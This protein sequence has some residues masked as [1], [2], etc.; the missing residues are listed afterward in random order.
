MKMPFLLVSNGQTSALSYSATQHTTRKPLWFGSLV[1]CL[2]GFDSVGWKQAPAFLTLSCVYN[3]LSLQAVTTLDSFSHDVSKGFPVQFC[4][5][6]TGLLLP[7]SRGEP[8]TAMGQISCHL[9]LSI[10]FFRNAAM[11]TCSYV[12]CLWLFHTVTA[13]LG[14]CNGHCRSSRQKNIY[15]LPLYKVGWPVVW[16][17]DLQN[18]VCASQGRTRSSV[19]V[20]WTENSY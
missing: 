18:A 10:N 17:G 1:V 16:N 11:T 20:Q 14:S 19:V 12:Y 9:F 8:S 3:S 15:S 4:L 7:S 6:D 13:E 2:P 5:R